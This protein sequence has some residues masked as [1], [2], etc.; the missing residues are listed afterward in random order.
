MWP[1]TAPGAVPLTRCAARDW[2]EPPSPRD[3]K[4][5]TRLI[6]LEARIENLGRSAQEKCFAKKSLRE[7]GMLYR[8]PRHFDRINVIAMEVN[9]TL[10]V[11]ESVIT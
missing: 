4:I 5:Q 6:A 8:A 9:R 1:P 7:L 11:K 2:T 3:Q 10:R